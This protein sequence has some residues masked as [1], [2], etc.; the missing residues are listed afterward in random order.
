MH[1]HAEPIRCLFAP[2]SLDPLSYS[3]HSVP[4]PHWCQCTKEQAQ[5]QRSILI[6]WA[7]LTKSCMRRELQS[8]AGKQLQNSMLNKI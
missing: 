1:R 4:A 2:H 3:P 8:G 6:E 5:S 7:R